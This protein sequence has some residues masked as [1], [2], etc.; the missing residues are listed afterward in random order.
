MSALDQAGARVAVIIP[1]RDEAD[2]V[3]AVVEAVRTELGAEVIVVDNGSRDGSGAVAERH[4]AR[5]IGEARRGYGWA[6]RTGCAAAV[7]SDVVVIIDGD[8]SMAAADIHRLLRPI[9]RDEAD[10]VCGARP[11]ASAAMPWHQRAGNHVI[12][13]LLRTLYGLPL[14]ELGPFR[15]VRVATLGS[16]DLPGSRYAWPAQMLARA[17]R[18]GLRVAEVPVGY[19]DRTGGRSKIGG[20]VRGSFGAAW[21]VGWALIGERLR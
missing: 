9:F 12:G 16:L 21:G 7:G 15:A 14:R 4:G 17:S 10:I 5:V 6:C 1:V 2:S 8:G 11:L 13:L 3:G 20:S 19:A 18:A